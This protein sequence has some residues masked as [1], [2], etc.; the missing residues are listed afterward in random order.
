VVAG[1]AKGGGAGLVLHHAARSNRR[2]DV[3]MEAEAAQRR[4]GGARLAVGKFVRDAVVERLRMNAE[5][6]AADR[7]AEGLALTAGPLHCGQALAVVQVC[8]I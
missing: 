4:E 2:L 3:W 1:L 5:F 8:S 6:V 7:W